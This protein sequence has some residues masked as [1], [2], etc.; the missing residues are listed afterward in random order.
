MTTIVLQTN[1]PKS[2]EFSLNIQR[3]LNI[4]VSQDEAQKAVTRYV[5]LNLSNQ[6]S[7]KA[8]VLFVAERGYWRVPVHLT[9]PSQGDVGEIGAID[10]D[11][12][13]GE[14]MITDK[15]LEGIETRADYLAQ[16]FTRIANR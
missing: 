6:M 13:S 16:R 5:A 2:G 15:I 1:P 14:L 10:V 3:T 9:F 8:P 4:Q 7:G 12:E 11:I